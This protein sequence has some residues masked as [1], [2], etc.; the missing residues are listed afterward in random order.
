MQSRC[1]RVMGVL[2]QKKRFRACDSPPSLI[3]IAATDAERTERLVQRAS[4]IL[5]REALGICINPLAAKRQQGFAHNRF[6]GVPYQAARSHTSLNAR[7]PDEAIYFIEDTLVHNAQSV[8]LTYVIDYSCG[9]LQ[10]ELDI[11]GVHAI[12]HC[13]ISRVMLPC[14]RYRLCDVFS[15]FR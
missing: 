7:V 8:L 3:C 14:K 13:T 11:Q 15:V 1:R 4:R 10:E 12:N 9:P 5:V 2:D 6:R